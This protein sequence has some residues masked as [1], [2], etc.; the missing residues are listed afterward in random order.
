MARSKFGF[1]SNNFRI[2]LVTTTFSTYV[3]DGTTSRA[4]TI[5]VPLGA[6][7]ELISLRDSY[8][9]T[10][11]V[12]TRQPIVV[13]QDAA[14]TTFFARAYTATFAASSNVVLHAYPYTTDTGV[15]MSLP[16]FVL[17]GGYKIVSSI[18]AGFDVADTHVVQLLV[19]EYC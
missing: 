15:V 19:K 4:V 6:M 17:P 18:A 10:A 5:T 14:S 3:L 13:V 9:A 8:T 1:D 2:E 12:G 11:T 16:P 7:W